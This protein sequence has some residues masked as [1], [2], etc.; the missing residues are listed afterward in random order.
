MASQ[1]PV[2]TIPTPNSPQWWRRIVGDDF[3]SPLSLTPNVCNDVNE[4]T[5]IVSGVQ[6][7]FIMPEN[8]PHTQRLSSGRLLTLN[9]TPQPQVHM[10]EVT[11]IH[12]RGSLVDSV[13]EWR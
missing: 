8:N 11:N 2:V 6:H 7:G 12:Y 3:S 10:C 9:W 4:I 1:V 5:E 13:L